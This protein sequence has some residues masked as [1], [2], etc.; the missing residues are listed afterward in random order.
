[1]IMEKSKVLSNSKPITIPR[2]IYP[3]LLA[4]LVVGG[5][6]IASQAVYGIGFPL[7]DAWIH[8]TYARNLA[9]HLEWSFV[10]GQPSAG[11]T[12][13]L[14]SLLLSIGY[15]VR[16]NPYLWTFFLSAAAMAALAVTAQLWSHAL[17]MEIK[18][19]VPW[20]GLFLAGEWHLGWAAASGMETILFALS[21]VLMFYLLRTGKNS[22]LV[23]AVIGISVWIRPDGVTLLGPAL[24]QVVFEGKTCRERLIRAG[25]VFIPAGVLC[26]GYLAFN[27]AISH[28]WLPNTFFA[29]QMEYAAFQQS[30]I[31]E[32]IFSLLTLPLIGAGLFLL[33][34]FLVAAWKAYQRRNWHVIAAILWWLGYT[35]VYAV[36]LPVTYQHGRYLI[37]AMPV[38]FVIGLT[39]LLEMTRNLRLDRRIRSNELGKRQRWARLAAIEWI[40]GLTV[41]WAVMIGVGALAY[42]Q[43]VA[44]IETEMVNSAKWIAT[45]TPENAVI[46]A[47][48]IGALGYFGDRKIL[49]LAGLVSPDVIPIIRDEKQ[50]AAYLNQNGAD[51]LMTFPGW[52]DELVKNKPIVYQTTGTYSPAAGGENMAVY[53]WK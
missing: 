37:P 38:Y 34:G 43:D 21:I 17:K 18:T 12:A 48:D 46:A 24:F 36:R 47:H 32:R 3:A 14:W 22:W 9:T 23:G 50:L 26:A 11:S 6:L 33:P 1:M 13:P 42:A 44:I 8:Q 16:L 39:G 19:A 28:T 45:N 41:L 20:V 53:L 7:D 10:P 25:E 15:F 30:P 52:Y 49:D 27:Q 51:Y 2:L 40:A 35:L 29:K 31:L 4:F 5:Y